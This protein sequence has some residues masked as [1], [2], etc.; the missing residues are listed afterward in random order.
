MELAAAAAAGA[1]VGS[2]GLAYLDAKLHI[3]KDL[4]WLI[5]R[6]AIQREWI[7]AVASERTS[8]YYFLEQ[9]AAELGSAEAIWAREEIGGCHSWIDLLNK[10]H[11]FAG[12]FLAQGVRRGDLVAFFMPNSP[13]F[14]FAWVGL[15]AIG[16]APAMIN[17]HLTGS[18]LVHCLGL[19]GAKLV[20]M[21]GDPKALAKMVEVWPEVEVRGG[22][23]VRFAVL[24]DVRPDIYA[25]PAT[26]PDDEF[27]RGLKASDPMAL[28]YTSG[29]TGMPKGCALPVR[30]AF[31]HGWGSLAGTNPVQ[32][33]DARYYVC[34]PYYH[35]TGGINVM[36][37][38]LS[39]NTA[40]VAPKFSVSGFWRDVRDSRATW[41][42]YVGETLRYL[43]A[44]PPS[45]LDRQH[46]VYGI[47]G[48]GL[49]PDVWNRFRDRFGITEIFEFFNSTEGMLSLDNNSLNDY[50]AHAVGHHGFLQRWKYHRSYVPVAVDSDTGDIAR[51][52]D[53]GFAY[54]MPYNVGGEILVQ[55]PFEREFPGYWKDPE[56]TAKKFVRDV[57]RKGDCYFRTGDALRRDDDGRWFFLDRL[58]D[59]FRWK[60][61]NVSTAE[62]SE[63]LGK[64][65][66]ILDANVYGVQI[67]GHDGKA[68]TAA[69]YIDPALK[70]T[71]DHQDFLRHARSHLPRYAVPL[72]LRHVEAPLSTHN[73]KQNKAPLKKEGVDPEKVSPGDKVLWIDSHGKGATYIP[74]TREDWDNLHVG[75]AKL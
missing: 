22:G 1:A 48:N 45:P 41:F 38:L 17:Y 54:R 27:R 57:F 68:G 56:A 50:T 61:E 74:F 32:Q 20:L 55:V 6:R 2:A 16:A 66:G 46:Q 42:V 24:D 71:F 7:R 10:A 63:V 39:G 58:G 5:G 75:K 28:F 73:N 37:Q 47:Y 29:T 30:A 11:Q 43:L 40:C 36:A 51:N 9:R 70:K 4:R 3:R 62:V 31:G 52:P 69:I 35:G 8:M 13:D 33:K 18:A 44:A 19:S 65:P 25:L 14:I 49:R 26:R 53:T 12:W 23:N 34:M 64:Y 21:D 72:F 59:T 67:P 60:G 15:W